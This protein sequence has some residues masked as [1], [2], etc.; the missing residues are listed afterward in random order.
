MDIAFIGLGQMGR[1]LDVNMLKSGAK[2]GATLCV[3]MPVLAAA[4]AT[5]QMALLEGHGSLDKGAMVKVREKLLGAQF[6]A[7]QE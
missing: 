2:F 7:R 5:Y 3:P 4:T 6:R 1:P